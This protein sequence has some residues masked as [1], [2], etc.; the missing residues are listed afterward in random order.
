MKISRRNFVNLGTA[1]V[2]ASPLL[3][4]ARAATL[5][6]IDPLGVRNDFPILK[7]TN[8]LNTP[9]HSVSPNQVVD[10]GVQFY[11]DRGNPA[12]SIGPFLAEGREVRAKFAKLVGAEQGEIGLIQA[13]TEAENIVVNNLDLKAG[14]NVVTD[15]LQYNASYILYDHLAKTRGVEVRM[16]RSDQTGRI[17]FKEFEAA[18]DN[19]TRIV[20]VSFVSHENGLCHD[21]RPLADLAHA[22]NAYI[23]VDAIQG[24]GMLELDVKKA[25]IDFMGCGTYK[26]LLASYGTA[27]FYVRRDLLELIKADRLGTFSVYDMEKFTD[28]RSYPDAAKYGQATPAFGAISVVGTALDYINRVGVKNI[29]TH[30]VALA[31]QIRDNLVNIGLKTDTPEENRSA[32]VSFFHGKDNAKVRELYQ[33]ENIKVSYKHE[34]KKIRIGASLFN[35]QSD[36]DHFNAVC[37][38]IAKLESV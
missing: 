20:S 24:V 7:T 9:Y 25:D 11:K 26:W 1:A 13:T 36:V 14:D 10:A 2:V 19:K 35:N 38:E 34:G 6:D 23:Y 30:T 18:I 29:E 37:R 28:F 22:H 5:R 31:H 15:D 8:Y 4:K 27:F 3:G 12:E 16:V 32:I 33:N 21:L 17:P